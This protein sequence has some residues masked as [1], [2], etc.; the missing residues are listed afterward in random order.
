[1]PITELLPLVESLPHAD[2][3]KLMQFLLTRFAQEEGVPLEL[4]ED[5]R[6][7]PLWNIIGMA[8]GT[9]KDVAKRHDEYLYGAVR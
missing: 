8:E 6:Q 4:P 5:R 1:M 3:L 9:E 7:D 2:K